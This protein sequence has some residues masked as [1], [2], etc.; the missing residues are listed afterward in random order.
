M[1]F[2]DFFLLNFLSILFL[3][4]YD[5]LDDVISVYDFYLLS[6][7]EFHQTFLSI[8]IMIFLIYDISCKYLGKYGVQYGCYGHASPGGVIYR[9][10]C[11]RSVGTGDDPGAS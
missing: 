6:F 3:D 10:G 4:L 2:L 8:S 1:L 7:L 9:P 5:Y 11:M